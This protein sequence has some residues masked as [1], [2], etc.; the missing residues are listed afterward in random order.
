MRHR[1]LARSGDGSCRGA[2]GGAERHLELERVERRLGDAPRT[3]L[4]RKTSR[5]SA[6]TSAH[7]ASFHAE[8]GEFDEARLA[9]VAG[10]VSLGA[11]LVDHERARAIEK[12]VPSH[13]DVVDR[14]VETRSRAS[15]VLVRFFV[16][17]FR[18]SANLLR[19]FVE[20]A[21]HGDAAAADR[22]RRR[23]QREA[24]AHVD[25]LDL[26]GQPFGLP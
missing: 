17:R 26:A 19:H 12:A 20:R 10:V 8:R 22:D 24:D 14:E 5:K 7:A 21:R 3:R 18:E 15:R 25:G 2:G 9:V 6:G 4:A 11:C 13:A 23:A 16:V 1:F